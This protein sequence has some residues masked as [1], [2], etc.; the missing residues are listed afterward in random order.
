MSRNYKYTDKHTLNMINHIARDVIKY[1]RAVP[2]E[3]IDELPED[4]FFPVVFSMV[5]EHKAG[6]PVEPHMRCMFAVPTLPK[7]LLVDVE[8]GLYDLLPTFEVADTPAEP[9]PV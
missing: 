5:H 6:K 3:C 8:M 7:R 1:N 9:T 2:Q 4:K